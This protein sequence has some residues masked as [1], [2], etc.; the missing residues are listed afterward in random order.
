M[1]P[2]PPLSLRQQD[3]PKVAPHPCST[4]GVSAKDTGHLQISTGKSR[5]FLDAE[6]RELMDHCL[7]GNRHVSPVL[8]DSHTPQ[9]PHLTVSPSPPESSEASQD[10]CPLPQGLAKHLCGRD[11]IP[12]M[13]A[14]AHCCT[15]TQ[16]G[17][18]TGR[19]LSLLAR[20]VKAASSSYGSVDS[21]LLSCS[22]VVG[23]QDMP[24][25]GLEMVEIT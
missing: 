16:Q 1:K 10:P 22:S 5:N 7:H 11:H 19:F 18:S 9:I 12:A 17:R 2:G 21:M 13:R 6:F 15:L 24:L 4:V 8:Q 23:G 25:V 20:W 14:H 3:L